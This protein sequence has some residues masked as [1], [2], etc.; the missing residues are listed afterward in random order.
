MKRVARS[1]I[2][3]ETQSLS[4]GCNIAI[5]INRLVSEILHIDGS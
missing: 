4:D 5:Y 1:T 3:A 2:A